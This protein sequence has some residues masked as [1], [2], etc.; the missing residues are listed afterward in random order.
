MGRSATSTVVTSIVWIVVLDGLVRRADQPLGPLAR[1]PHR[2]RTAATSGRGPR[3]PPAISVRNLTMGY[4]TRVLLEGASF[5]VQRGEILVILGGSGS[6][7]SSMMKNLIGLYEPM[8][9]GRADR[10]TEPRARRAGKSA[11]ACSASLA[12]M[13]QSGALFGSLTTL[14]NVRFPL[15]EFTAIAPAGEE[16]HGA[17]AAAP[18]RDGPCRGA[19]AGRALRRHAQ[20]RGHRARDGAR[21]GHSHAGRALGGPRPDHRGEPGPHHPV[22]AREPRL[23]LRGRDPR[24]DAASSPSPTAPSCS[25]RASRS[26]IA[27]GKPA[28]LRDHSSDPRVRQFFNR[29]PDATVPKTET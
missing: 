4:G 16:P 17:H 19:D 25:T 18:G 8:A 3:R 13:Y 10:R 6:G 24:A 23:H 1:W 26:I 9:R 29:E 11:R 14:E 15:D 21:R 28:E 5:D 20:A 7:K 22:A 12:I 27:T 2:D